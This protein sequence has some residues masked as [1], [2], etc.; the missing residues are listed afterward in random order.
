M[1]KALRS[2]KGDESVAER[3]IIAKLVELSSSCNIAN[4]AIQCSYG[5]HPQSVRARRRHTPAGDGGS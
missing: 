2:L 4:L 1:L 3:Q 5:P